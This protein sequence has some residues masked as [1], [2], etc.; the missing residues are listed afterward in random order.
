MPDRSKPVILAV[1]DDERVRTLCAAALSEEFEVVPAENGKQALQLFYQKRPDVVLLDVTMPVMDGWETC[2]RIRDLADV[3]VIML[4]AHGADHDVVRGLDAG[5]DDYVTKPFRPLQLAARIRAVLRRKR[6]STAPGEGAESELLSFD[7]GNLVVDTAR[8]VAV[9]RGKDVSLSAT[10]YRLLETLAR[11]AGRV[12]THDQILEHVWGHAYAGE[13][14]Y[15][16]TYVGL[17]RNKI[18]EDP[19]SPRYVLA[20][21]GLGYYLDRRAGRGDENVDTAA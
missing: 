14:G 11:H 19:H 5:A 4:T 16:K 17:L 10:E 9:V 21:R 1:D 2:R 18:E 20:R 3:P 13:T 6:R 8:R 15:V 7:N 12:L